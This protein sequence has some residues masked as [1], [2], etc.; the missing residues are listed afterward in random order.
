M[1]QPICKIP[2]P[3]RCS[4]LKFLLLAAAVSLWLTSPGIR[5]AEEAKLPPGFVRLATEGGPLSLLP[6]MIDGKLQLNVEPG[7][8]LA[9]VEIKQQARDKYLVR[10]PDPDGMAM[11]A[12]QKLGIKGNQFLITC[13]PT[14]VPNR[15]YKLLKIEEVQEDKGKARKSP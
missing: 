6:M 1:K 10:F 12:K 5:A 9:P 2:L 13:E 4:A 7:C 11:L 3:V 8:I 15:L 14:D